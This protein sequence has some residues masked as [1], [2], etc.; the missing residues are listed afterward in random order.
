MI[1]SKSRYTVSQFYVV[2]GSG[3][4]LLSGKTAHELKLIQLVNKINETQTSDSKSGT[5]DHK[6]TT[7]KKT[8]LPSSTDGNI[9]GF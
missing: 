3:G 2:A 8:N 7:E 9:N 5:N 6:E 1:E 4:N